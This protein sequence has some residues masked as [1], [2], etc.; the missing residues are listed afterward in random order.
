MLQDR[1]FTIYKLS[2]RWKHIE[3]SANCCWRC[4][5]CET[6]GKHALLIGSIETLRGWRTGCVRR[7][8]GGKL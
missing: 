3:S 4:K 1:V 2:S 7:I 6:F 8:C 5:S